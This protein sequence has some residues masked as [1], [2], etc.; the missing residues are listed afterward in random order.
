MTEGGGN[1]QSEMVEKRTPFFVGTFEP[2]NLYNSR[3]YAFTLGFIQNFSGD[4]L[5]CGEPNI[6]KEMIEKKFSLRISSTGEIDLDVSKISGRYD[7]VFAFEII[8]H[9]M[10][11]LWFLT[12]VRESL[13]PGG[14]VYLSTPINKPKFFWRHDHFHE[15]DEYRLLNLMDKAGFVVEKK[16]RR[17]FY[18]LSGVR[19]LIR[20]ALRTGTMFLALRC[21]PDVSTKR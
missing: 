16:E 14:I 21:K 10:N 5:D 8:E 2:E 3:R 19:P 9:L 11:P 18:S 1:H 20:L 13:R 15:F 12:Q 7:V 6:L 17:R 4:I